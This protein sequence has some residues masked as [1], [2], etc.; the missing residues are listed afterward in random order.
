MQILKL[1][2][3]PWNGQRLSSGIFRWLPISRVGLRVVLQRK[4]F[5]FFLL[6]GLMN[7][8]FYFAIIYFVAQLK[9]EVE[10]RGGRL[11]PF[12]AEQVFVGSGKS[13]RDFVSGQS[14]VVMLFLGFAGSVL[15]GNDFRFGAIPFYL[16]KPISKLHYFLGKLG[17]ASLLTSF[18]TLVPATLLFV[19]YGSLTESTNYF[20]ENWRILLAIV[21]YGGLVSVTSAVLVLGISALLQKTIPIVVA[22]GAIFAFL[23]IVSQVIRNAIPGDPWQWD[24]LSYWDVLRWTSCCM[25]GIE[26]EKYSPRMPACAAVLALWIGLSLWAFW[27]RVQA[28]EVVK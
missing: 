15:V 20:G 3:R 22:W 12:V 18:I 8:L 28:V 23:P 10:Q 2:Y 16:S 17:A 26:F 14:M 24:L 19:E 25:F 9:A 13:Y 27:R 6:L 21:G 5:W 4:I 7:F 1:G 11:P